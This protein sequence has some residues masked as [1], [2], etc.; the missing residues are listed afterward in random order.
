MSPGIIMEEQSSS[1]G[2]A[3]KPAPRGRAL[4]IV[5][6][7]LI[8]IV[9]V[10]LAAAV[11]GLFSPTAPATPQPRIGVLLSQTGALSQCGPGYTK[12]PK[13]GADQIYASR[14]VLRQPARMCLAL[15][16]TDS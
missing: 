9:V 15:D 13:L 11:G 8:V 6:A 7:V 5:V 1:S 4:W 2:E 3:P 12:A 16:Q 10:V 14:R